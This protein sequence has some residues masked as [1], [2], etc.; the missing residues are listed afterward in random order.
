MRP[1]EGISPSEQLAD[2][3][4]LLLEAYRVGYAELTPSELAV[5]DRSLNDLRPPCQLEIFWCSG[6]MEFEVLIVSRDPERADGEVN[7]HGPWSATQFPEEVERAL[8]EDRWLRRATPTDETAAERVAD[9]LRGAFSMVRQFI[10]LTPSNRLLMSMSIPVVGVCTL[11]GGSSLKT[12]PRSVA[13][14]ALATFRNR[15]ADGHFSA[16]VTTIAAPALRAYC[17]THFY[18]LIVLQ[19]DPLRDSLA[20][21]IIRVRPLDPPQ[22]VVAQATDK[23]VLIYNSGLVL[24]EGSDPARSVRLLNIVFAAISLEG[25]SCDAVRQ[26]EVHTFSVDDATLAVRGSSGQ[27]SSLRTTLISPFAG[28]PMENARSF[29]RTATVETLW[30][31]CQLAERVK[32]DADLSTDLVFLVQAKTFHRAFEYAQ[33]FVL[34]WLVVEKHIGRLWLACLESKGIMS[35]RRDK[36]TK[37][38]DSWTADRKLELLNIAGHV[39]D[40]SYTQMMRF[41]KIRNDFVHKG[42]L[43]ASADA[44]S[45]IEFVSPLVVKRL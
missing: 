17:G 7:V 22:R 8:S 31:A 27:L 24:V 37:S 13:A 35:K 41:K 43:V 21:R 30:R 44:W 14:N 42:T 34:A 20:A 6:P 19:E 3:L 9:Y 2:W 11:N 39:D 29:A 1:A 45:L 36:L 40:S 4:R 12:D 18:P 25:L 23:S 16:P 33:A 5:L 32:N 15:E 28:G 10:F 26:D 38:P